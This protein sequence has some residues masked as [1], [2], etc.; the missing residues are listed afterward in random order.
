MVVPGANATITGSI[1]LDGVV[2]LE[3]DWEGRTGET[4]QSSCFAAILPGR[5]RNLH[6]GILGCRTH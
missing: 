5:H 1:D 6:H 3:A 4:R 2:S